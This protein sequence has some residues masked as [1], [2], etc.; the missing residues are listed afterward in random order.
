MDLF[1][2]N[3]L[4]EQLKNLKKD[5]KKYALDKYNYDYG[6]RRIYIADGRKETVGNNI[7]IVTQQFVPTVAAFTDENFVK[8]KK[9]L[10]DYKI[11]N[12][13]ITP[14]FL[15]PIENISKADI[16]DY[17]IWIEKIVDIFQPK[18]IVALGEESIFS[19]FKRKV[20]LRDF[21]G[22]VIG[23]SAT[24]IDVYLSYA[25]SYY[26]K[27]SEYEDPSFKEFILKNDWGIIAKRYEE[28][29]GRDTKTNEAEQNKETVT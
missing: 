8:L 2:G 1:Y 3:T 25:T 24:N 27:A 17:S 20:I 28:L 19:F 16:K 13:I 22:K 7:L 15:I 26:N 4:E 23:R 9:I 5:I 18:L 21:H 12:Y 6:R 14:N 29:I 10:H 11:R